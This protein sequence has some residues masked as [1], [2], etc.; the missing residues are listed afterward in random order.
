MTREAL[1]KK[2]EELPPA[3]QL[4]LVEEVWASLNWEPLSGDSS[5][6]QRQDLDRRVVEYRANPD[7]VIE[8][9]SVLAEARQ[10]ARRP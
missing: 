7:A 5:E 10:R 9:E 1:R 3:D 8:G 4:A 2:I 6:A